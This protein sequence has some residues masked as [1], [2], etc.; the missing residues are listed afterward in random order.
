MSEV[1]KEEINFDIKNR[2]F[3]LKKSDFKENK[4]EQFLFDYLS[5]NLIL[6]MLQ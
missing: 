3:S 1:N 4:K 5:N 2:N 6:N